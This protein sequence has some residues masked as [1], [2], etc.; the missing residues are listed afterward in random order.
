MNFQY[1]NLSK[2]LICALMPMLAACAAYDA[3]DADVMELQA[4]K[5][6]YNRAVIAEEVYA[7]LLYGIQS[8][9]SIARVRNTLKKKKILNRYQQ[10]KIDQFADSIKYY[11]GQII[12]LEMEKMRL[13]GLVP[14]EM[15]I[16]MTS[17]SIDVLYNRMAVAEQY[18]QRA[19]DMIYRDYKHDDKDNVLS[20]YQL[21]KFRDISFELKRI[22]AAQQQ[23]L[24]QKAQL[25]KAK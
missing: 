23:L 11:E 12:C 18:Y 8:D 4:V 17:D 15:R 5:D 16:N 20:A 24:I 2:S 1:K 9:Y 22:R 13:E 21:K 7:N 3:T 19:F 6:K 10:D 14:M 25:Q